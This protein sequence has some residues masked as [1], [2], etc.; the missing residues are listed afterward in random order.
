MIV[1]ERVFSKQEAKCRLYGHAWAP[2]DVIQKGREFEATLLCDR[3]YSK[4]VERIGKRDGIV[5]SRQIRYARGYIKKGGRV[6]IKEKGQ[7]RKGVW[8]T[9]LTGKEEA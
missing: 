5:K 6:S 8:Q 7:L 4:K 1:N 3:C 9:K 2:Y